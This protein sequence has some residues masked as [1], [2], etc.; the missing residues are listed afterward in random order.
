MGS[1][2]ES[3]SVTVTVNE[4]LQKVNQDSGNDPGSMNH[5]PDST[6]ADIES[7]VS[8][9]EVKKVK[10]HEHGHGHHGHHHGH[11]KHGHS[12]KEKRASTC[13]P[14]WVKCLIP[15]LLLLAGG[16][17]LLILNRSGLTVGELINGGVSS[18]VMALRE[19]QSQ[20]NAQISELETNL[21]NKAVELKQA[22]ATASNAAN[23]D[24]EQLS[25][26]NNKIAELQTE[27]TH[28]D[29]K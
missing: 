13:C 18:D 14:T 9:H 10:K 27:K 22:I 21:Q 28:I 25:A 2:M 15:L 16:A 26:L 4:G 8:D 5:Q 7:Q 17:T 3:Q 29:Q 19:S 6:D 12:K 24:S 1:G 23:G 11:C 20:L